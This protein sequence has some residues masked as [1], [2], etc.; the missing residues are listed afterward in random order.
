MTPLLRHAKKTYTKYKSLL[1]SF[2]NFFMHVDIFL[3]NIIKILIEKKMMLINRQI[4]KK[5]TSCSNIDDEV[6]FFDDSHGFLCC[7]KF[8]SNLETWSV[9]VVHEFV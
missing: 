2:S 1:T 6:I 9:C 8:F 7:F 3:N 4:R 5:L